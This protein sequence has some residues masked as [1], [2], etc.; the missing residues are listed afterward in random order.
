MQEVGQLLTIGFDGTEAPPH[1]FEAIRR[2]Q[3]GGIVLFRRNIL[4]AQQV[5]E[6][7]RSL[8]GQAH[9]AGLPTLFI[10]IDQEGGTVRRLTGSDFIPLPSQMAMASANAPDLVERLLYLAGLEMAALGINQNYAPVLDV[11]VNPQNPVIGIRSFGEDPGDVARLGQHYIRGL[12]AAGI[13][14]TA[15]HFP[16]HG[17]TH[18]DSHK[19]LPTVAHPRERLESVELV[20]FR[21]AVAADVSAIMTAHVVFPAIEPTGLPAT[22]SSRVLTELIREELN[23]SGMVVTDSMEMQ[24]ITE[25]FGTAPGAQM[26]VQ[27]GADQVLVSHHQDQQQGAYQALLQGLAHGQIAQARIKDALYRVREA[28]DRLSQANLQIT[29]AQRKEA[30]TLAETLWLRAVAGTGALKKLPIRD[31]LVLVTF[32]DTEATEA[33]DSPTKRQSH[34]LAEALGTQLKRHLLLPRD[35]SPSHVTE[36]HAASRG[37]AL[38]VALD[39]AALHPSQLTVLHRTWTEGPTIALALSSPYDLRRLPVDALGL[40]AFDPSPEAMAAL[41]TVLRGD[42]PLM[43]RFPVSLEDPRPARHHS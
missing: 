25:K 34:P 28:K 20:P 41:I 14:A 6:L 27:A 5:G 26:A 21:A 24:A 31:T 35:P 16:G 23:F 18:Q 32:G 17:D 4:S 42:A 13:L 7:T 9:E 30:W 15:K 38:L 1:I 10:A 43:G 19:T 37:H 12:Q 36:V 8:Q 2:G 22:L 29:E 40:T 39:R 11:N 33:E 3:A